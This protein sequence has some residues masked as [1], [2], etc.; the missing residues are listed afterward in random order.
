MGLRMVEWEEWCRVAPIRS[1]AR[2]ADTSL[3]G[4]ALCFRHSLTLSLR[5]FR[6]G[7]EAG[8]TPPL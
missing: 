1:V 4:C 2:G 5:V 7:A 8:R 3:A 6:W